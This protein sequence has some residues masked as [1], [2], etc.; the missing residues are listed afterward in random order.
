MIEPVQSPYP[1]LKLR[2]YSVNSIAGLPLI[3]R[4]GIWI[5]ELEISTA[6]IAFVHR[7]LTGDFVFP[8]NISDHLFEIAALTFPAVLIGRLQRRKWAY[9]LGAIYAFLIAAD[10]AYKVWPELFRSAEIYEGLVL[11]I[12]A[13]IA[14]TA[15]LAFVGYARVWRGFGGKKTR[16]AI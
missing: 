9:L 13:A 1:R 14:S 5:F 12:L 16:E 2:E 11:P 4:S 8:T 7:L 15:I 10:I 3:L 6:F